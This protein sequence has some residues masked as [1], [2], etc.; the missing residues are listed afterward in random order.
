MDIGSNAT[1]ISVN[2][3]NS[4][5]S[6]GSYVHCV[7][8]ML[9]FTSWVKILKTIDKPK[10]ERLER[11]E[12]CPQKIYELMLRCWAHEPESRMSFAELHEELPKARPMQVKTLVNYV[13]LH[14][15]ELT[16]RAEDILSVVDINDD[17]GVW[18]GINPMGKIGYFQRVDTVA[19]GNN[20][21]G[22]LKRWRSGRSSKTE[23]R[24]SI[25]YASQRPKRQ[26]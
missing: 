18:K 3:R 11:P 4:G 2:N 23:N 16:F 26:R 10:L 22:K 7:Q 6:S 17:T 14:P 13:A 24:R 1:E 19:L 8:S 15:E 5:P 25:L 21:T 9:T 12:A 20:Q